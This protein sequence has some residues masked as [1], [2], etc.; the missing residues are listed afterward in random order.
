MTRKSVLIVDDHGTFRES[1]K[2]IIGRFAGYEV[3][4]EA[5]D[6]SQ[7]E[8]LAVALSPD[9]AVVDL[10]LPDK[11]GIQLTR[12]LHTLLPQTGIVIVSMHAKIDYILGALR[13]GARGYIVKESVGGCLLQAFEAVGRQEYYLDPAL[14]MEVAAKLLEIQEPGNSGNGAYGDLTVREQE[15]LRLL[16]QGKPTGAIADQLC[17]SP[18]TVTNHRANIMSK[19]D[20]HSSVELVRYAAKLGLLEDGF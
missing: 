1:L 8:R 18:K 17:I 10:S 7:G 19:L 12:V 5:A 13:S 6:A 20:L 15:I 16:A 3:V 2:G 9:L 14:S 4:G 11:S